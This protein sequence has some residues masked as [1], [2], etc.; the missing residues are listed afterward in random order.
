MS[1]IVPCFGMI[2]VRGLPV[3]RLLRPRQASVPRLLV[4]RRLLALRRARRQA[5]LEHWLLEVNST[6]S[7]W[8]SLMRV[9]MRVLIRNMCRSGG[10]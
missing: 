10:A 4:G 7:F 8:W 9:M 2:S 6:P 1:L 5:A 3:Q